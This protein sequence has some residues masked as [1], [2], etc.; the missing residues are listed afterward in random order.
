VFPL[1]IYK[2]SVGYYKFQFK[3]G[4]DTG[5]HEFEGMTT[6]NLFDVGT[7]GSLE[8]LCESLRH[9]DQSNIKS[10]KDYTQ[11]EPGHELDITHHRSRLDQDLGLG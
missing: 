3:G 1:H 11:G 5:Y 9:S 4:C 6:T 7:A 2:E 8:P 10:R